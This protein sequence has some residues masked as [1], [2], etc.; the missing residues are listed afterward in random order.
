MNG[1]CYECSQDGGSLDSFDCVFFFHKEIRY[2]NKTETK[3]ELQYANKKLS[4]TVDKTIY[5]PEDLKMKGK[6]S[7]FYKSFF[8]S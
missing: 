8:S 3:G 4:V 7:T 6:H 2:T 5:A 1:L